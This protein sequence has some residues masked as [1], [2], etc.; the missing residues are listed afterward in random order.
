MKKI[1]PWSYCINELNYVIYIE[2]PEIRCL[3]SNFMS[4]LLSKLLIKKVYEIIGCVN[5]ASKYYPTYTFYFISYL[6]RA[7]WQHSKF[8]YFNVKQKNFGNCYWYMILIKCIQIINCIQYSFKD[9]FFT[10]FVCCLKPSIGLIVAVIK[11]PFIQDSF[12]ILCIAFRSFFEIKIST[13][14]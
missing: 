6:R 7:N 2:Q 3:L 8:V 10:L 13:L 11:T 5:I 12:S 9:L 1:L 4:I 14:C